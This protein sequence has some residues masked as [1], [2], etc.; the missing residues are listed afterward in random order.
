MTR[1]KFALD[2]Y[3]NVY[4]ANGRGRKILG[5]IASLRYEQSLVAEAACAWWREQMASEKPLA[6]RGSHAEAGTEPPG[7][8]YLKRRW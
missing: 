2:E 1:A 6:V 3:G 8:W 5:H 7:S 4:Q